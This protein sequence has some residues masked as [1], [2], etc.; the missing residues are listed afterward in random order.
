MRDRSVIVVERSMVTISLAIVG[1]KSCSKSGEKSPNY[2][3]VLA[4]LW[5]THGEAALYYMFM[6]DV[7]NGCARRYTPTNGKVA[8]NV[9]REPWAQSSRTKRKVTSAQ[10]GYYLH[11]LCLSIARIAGHIYRIRKNLNNSTVVGIVIIDDVFDT[12]II[13]APQQS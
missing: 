7:V 13:A 9:I 4:P 6:D 1:A 2:Q 11:S 5:H 3:T 12:V 8:Y 10:A